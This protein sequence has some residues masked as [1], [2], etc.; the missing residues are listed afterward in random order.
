[1]SLAIV[2]VIGSLAVIYVPRLMVGLIATVLAIYLMRRSRILGAALIR[3]GAAHRDRPDYDRKPS[4]PERRLMRAHLKLAL[5]QAELASVL[6]AIMMRAR[7]I[8][9]GR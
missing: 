5:D 9:D 6:P 7:A 8:V 1:M 4:R 3:A 2:L